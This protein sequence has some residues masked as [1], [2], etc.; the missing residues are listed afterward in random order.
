MKTQSHHFAGSA[1]MDG[2]QEDFKRSFHF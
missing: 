1:T 2:E